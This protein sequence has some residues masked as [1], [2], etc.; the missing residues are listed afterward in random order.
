MKLVSNA[1]L[2]KKLLR[3][4]GFKESYEGLELEFALIDAL[5]HARTVQGVTQA[6][7]AKKIGTKQSAIAR[8]EAGNSNPTLAFI[9]RLSDALNIRVQVSV[10]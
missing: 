9:Q 2:Q 5:I 8:F 4:P 10:R 3:K 1:D 6:Q 7:L